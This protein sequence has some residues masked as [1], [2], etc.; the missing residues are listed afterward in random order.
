VREFHALQDREEIRDRDENMITISSYLHRD[1]LSDII[2][3][4]MYGDLQASDAN[5]ITQIVHFNNVYVSRYLKIFSEDLFRA[6]HKS[7]LHTRPASLKSDL[8]DMII[9]NPAYRNQRINE[10]ISNYQ[11][12]PGRFYRETPFHATLFFVQRNGY[13]EYI[14]SSRIK[15]VHRLAEKGARRI[16]DWVYDTIKKHADILADD[17]AMRLGIPR[18]QLLTSQEEMFDEFLKAENRLIEDFKYGRQIQDERKMVISDVAG[19]KVILE[20]EDQQ[21]LRSLLSSMNTC[22][23]VEEERHAGKYNATNFLVRYSPPK[24]RLLVAPPG[25]VIVDIMREKGLNYDSLNQKFADFIKTGEDSVYLEIIVCN[26]QEMLESEIGRCMHEDRII[27]QRLYQPYCSH[28]AK[29]IEYLMEYLFTF[30]AS[31]K[32][33]LADLPIKIWNRY[34][35]DYFEDVVRKLFHVPPDMVM[36]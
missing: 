8:K 34:L 12:E 28:L 24:D 21:H 23:V 7:V 10:L 17:R 3:R 6:L 18:Y 35:P 11:S 22:E 33:D 2:R 29:N 14:G 13:E 19:L 26:Y 16:I 4:W 30:P 31:S 36:E 5:L 32:A 25:S 20:D 27:E 9:A 15:R 1:V